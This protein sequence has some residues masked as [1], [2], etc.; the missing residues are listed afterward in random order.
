MSEIVLRGDSFRR[1]QLHRNNAFYGFLLNVCQILHE[2]LLPEEGG[3][4]A[5]PG[6]NR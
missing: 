5:R 6:A 3:V 2:E 1:V 4:V